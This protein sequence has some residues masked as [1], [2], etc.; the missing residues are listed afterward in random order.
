MGLCFLLKSLTMPIFRQIEEGRVG[1]RPFLQPLTWF[2]RNRK[3]K[4]YIKME[5]RFSKIT[6]PYLPY[7]TLRKFYDHQFKTTTNFY[8][9]HRNLENILNLKHG[10]L[11]NTLI[12]ASTETQFLE[13][14]N[15]WHTNSFLSNNPYTTHSKSSKF[16]K[17]SV[18]SCF[19]FESVVK[20][21]VCFFFL[22]YLQKN[23]NIKIFVKKKIYVC[24]YLRQ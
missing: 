4:N 14:I 23:A 8:Y 1:K 12:C 15:R 21:L 17:H 10:E 16:S 18:Q 7:R 2:G 22:I 13:I 6:E 3:L 9:F 19:L 20:R 11:H 24:T 5:C